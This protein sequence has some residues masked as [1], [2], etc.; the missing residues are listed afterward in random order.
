MDI[1]NNITEKL[2]N[3]M[4][5]GLY[6]I[7]SVI[8]GLSGDILAMAYFPGYSII[9]NMASDLGTGESGI[10][11][12]LGMIFS[13]LVAMPFY[14]YLSKILKTETT[15]ENVRRYFLY[16]SIISC[17]T[18]SLV[19]VF[20]SIESFY[21]IFFLHGLCAL[22]SWMSAIIYLILFSY[23]ILIDPRFSKFKAYL[24]LVPA[25]TIVIFLFTWLPIIEWSISV[26]I[27]IWIIVIASYVLYKKL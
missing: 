10:F 15:N 4:P 7:F 5:G 20:P 17:I 27:T 26:T 25:S 22:I 24:G 2:L 6:G 18:F 8:I 12:N 16:F 3:F 14:I 19:G 21:L 9:E 11:F 13:G 1:I 23:L